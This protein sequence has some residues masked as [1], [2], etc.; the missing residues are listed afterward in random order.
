MAVR[1]C[2]CVV[3]FMGW[4]LLLLQSLPESLRSWLMGSTDPIV[5]NVGLWG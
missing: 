1:R 5:R 4:L 2:N 3:T